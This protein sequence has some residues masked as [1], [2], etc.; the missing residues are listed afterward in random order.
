M[1][2]IKYKVKGKYQAERLQQ[3][4]ERLVAGPARRQCTCMIAEAVQHG[5]E[6]A[7]ASGP[8]AD[9]LV[10]Q[11]PSS[12]ACIVRNERGGAQGLERFQI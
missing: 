6:R 4:V 3:V 10:A 12:V 8:V 5:S 9:Q 11:H 2:C 1:I 7:I